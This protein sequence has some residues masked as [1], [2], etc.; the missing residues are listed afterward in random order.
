LASIILKLEN[1]Y[2][3]G[4]DEPVKSQKPDGFVKSPQTRRANPEE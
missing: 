1:L 2:A 3:F 4:I